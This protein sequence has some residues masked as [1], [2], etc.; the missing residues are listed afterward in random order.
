MAEEGGVGSL[1]RA[2]DEEGGRR[3]VAQALPCWGPFSAR[4]GGLIRPSAPEGPRGLVLHTPQRIPGMARPAWTFQSMSARNHDIS[5]I[6]HVL[7]SS[8]TL[9]SLL[10]AQESPVLM[11]GSPSLSPI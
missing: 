5:P 4:V 9:S 11:K 3:K 10:P 2:G 7:A 1:D 8:N 6:L